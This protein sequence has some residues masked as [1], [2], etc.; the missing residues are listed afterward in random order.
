MLHLVMSAGVHCSLQQPSTLITTDDRVIVDLFLE[1]QQERFTCIEE[2][3]MYMWPLGD[4]LVTAV[5][6]YKL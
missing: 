1:N 4:K 5:E 3:Q 2:E 6:G